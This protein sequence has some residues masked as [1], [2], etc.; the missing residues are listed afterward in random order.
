MPHLYVTYIWDFGDK[1]TIIVVQS[2]ENNSTIA[3]L[4]NPKCWQD[5]QKYIAARKV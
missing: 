5:Q 3:C 4:M 1:S 2:K